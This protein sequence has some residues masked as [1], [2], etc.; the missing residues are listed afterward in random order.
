[1][2]GGQDRGLDQGNAARLDKNEHA[3]DDFSENFMYI[4]AYFKS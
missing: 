2:D 3:F 4:P 1:M